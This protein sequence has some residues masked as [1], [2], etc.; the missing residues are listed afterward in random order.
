MAVIEREGREA[1][2]VG[3]RTTPS[4]HGELWDSLEGFGLA[5]VSGCEVQ[6]GEHVV[7]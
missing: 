6:V 5:S 7:G 2:K 4:Q 1:G 3:Y